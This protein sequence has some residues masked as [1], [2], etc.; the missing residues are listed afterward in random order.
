[1]PF[2]LGGA[3]GR[4]WVLVD[5][6]MTIEL[7]G[8]RASH[9]VVAHF[10]DTWR[11]DDGVR[12]AG[13]AVGHV[14]PVG[15]PLA[16]YT[17]RDARGAPLV[18]EIRRRFEI[19]DG[20][21]GW[22]STAFA[23]VAHPA[24]EV[25]DWRGPHPAQE[26]GRYA[27]I[28]HSGTLTIMPGAYGTSQTGMTD[29]VPSATDDVL[30]WLHAI[31]LGAGAAPVSLTL[32]PLAGGRPGSDLVVAA[33]TLFDG[34]ASPLVR[35]PRVAVRVEGVA[36]PDAR[37]PGQPSVAVDLG[38]VIRTRRAAPAHPPGLDRDEPVIG[39]GEPRRDPRPD[40]AEPGEA[41]VVDLS[42]GP[43]ARI[44]LAGWPVPAAD[45]L[46]GGPVRE[47]GGGRSIELLP[48]PSIPVEV[49]IVDGATGAP[50]PARVRFTAADGR[51]LPPVGHRDEI[52]PGFFEDTGG[53]LILGS[54]AY[55]YVPGAFPIGLPLGAVEVEVVAGFDRPP[56]RARI[57]VDPATRHLRIPLEPPIDL[58]GGRWVTADSHVHFL[59][60]S[61]ALLQAAAE[62]VDVVNLLAA[63]WGDLY[64]NVTDLAWGSGAAPGGRP[65]VA[66]GTENRQNV[67]GHL[68]LLGAHRMTIPLA[69]GGPPEGPMAGALEVL[70]ADWLDRCRVAGGLAVAAHFPLPY[71]EIAAD[72]VAGKVEAIETQALSP[73][74]D[75]P[76]VLEWYRFLDLGYR[77]PV[78]GGT[79]KMSTEV[80]VGAVR[81]YTHLLDDG[82]LTFDRWAAAVRAGRTFVTSG[83]ILELAVAGREPGD[84]IRM[85]GPGRLDIAIRARAA[86]P[87]IRDVELVVNGRVV[88]AAS[89]A[90]A[91]PELR[92]E[93]AVEIA[94]G[95][96]I[97][98]RVRGRHHIESAFATSMAAHTS[99]VYVEVDGRP[100]VPRAEDAAVVEQVMLGTRAWVA[101]LAA[102]A[103]P[104]ERARMLTFLDAT[105]DDF[106]RRIADA[107]RR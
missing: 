55:A 19:N 43:D 50:L 7:D 59:A 38:T 37:A 100:L 24:N 9:L 61:T 91:V 33:V 41:L 31:E 30:L 105:L 29:F 104:A 49:E 36:G 66:V 56:Y 70:L 81:A 84:V 8:G 86:Q 97:A 68:A 54:A 6:P 45:V 23:A 25:L 60:P 90:V 74:L 1:M 80:P 28:G 101:E 4:R 83:P 3:S 78:V 47:P 75:D 46:A 34:T 12:P 51:Y 15:E 48:S 87:V 89:A 53:D 106:R 95:S 22:G 77:L 27:A 21:L 14:V 69:S 18:R 65:I 11:D 67:L 10:C 96:W 40:A 17:V 39:W 44:D 42:F 57:E 35:G 85:R 98:A 73:G 52:N 71:A 103:E 26:A 94:A 62:G 79:D 63:Q 88:A 92:L 5:R 58:H 93:E 76:A 64:T 2:E 107:R 99:P 102:V 20:I 13:I 72:I 32:E 16:R 82:E